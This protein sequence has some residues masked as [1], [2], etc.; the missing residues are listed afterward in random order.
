MSITDF[1]FTKFKG[2]IA[3]VKNELS[4]VIILVMAYIIYQQNLYVK[5]LTAQQHSEDKEYMIF[6]RDQYNETNKYL[7]YSRQNERNIQYAPNR[8]TAR[9]QRY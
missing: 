8:D 9:T 5:E 2:L 7:N 4:T 1:D 6:F 3:F